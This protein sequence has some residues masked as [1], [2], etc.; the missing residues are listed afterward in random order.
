MGCKDE[1]RCYWTWQNISS[2]R[3]FVLI[4]TWNRWTM[5]F[6]P[7]K[8]L[9]FSFF[10]RSSEGLT[11]QIIIFPPISMA[12]IQIIN[13][14]PEFG[15]IYNSL[16]KSISRVNTCPV[17]SGRGFIYCF[18]YQTMM[19]P[20]LWQA[21]YWFRLVQSLSRQTKVVDS[22]AFPTSKLRTDSLFIWNFMGELQSIL[23]TSF[24]L[25]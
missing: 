23:L 5:Q 7:T 15:A 13:T 20:W 10:K 3:N 11:I 8:K 18:N 9:Y 22:T 6:C 16:N 21:R 25:H 24:I 12:R 19:S 4:H 2:Y 14:W 1:T 17:G